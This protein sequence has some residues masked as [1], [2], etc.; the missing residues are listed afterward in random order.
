MLVSSSALLPDRQGSIELG[1]LT[2][3]SMAVHEFAHLAAAR[4]CRVH[5]EELSLT[6]A[7][8][9]TRREAA[10]S[11][12]QEILIAAAGP[13]ANL[14][15][16]ACVFSLGRVGQWLAFYNLVLF[17]A[18]LLP[19]PATDGSRI[20]KALAARRLLSASAQRA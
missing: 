16:A 5:V 17:L 13:L 14:Y 1:V 18:S 10:A 11:P 15:I 3:F 7:G 4:S 19:L 2:V 8:F 12:L 9:V 6:L 20:L